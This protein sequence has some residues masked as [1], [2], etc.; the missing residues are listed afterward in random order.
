MTTARAPHGSVVHEFE[1]RVSCQASECARW[2]LSCRM[3]SQS[4]AGAT[5]RQPALSEVEGSCPPSPRLCRPG[6]GR[7]TKRVP[8]GSRSSRA[9]A[10]GSVRCPQRV[11]SVRCPQRIRPLGTADT[12]TRCLA[13][14]RLTTQNRSRPRTN[15]VADLH[16]AR[17]RPRNAPGR[18]VNGTLRFSGGAGRFG[19]GLVPPTRDPGRRRD[20][21]GISKNDAGILKND[22][23]I[24]TKYPG[25]LQNDL[26]FRPVVC[27]ISAQNSCRM[28]N[29]C[30]SRCFVL[31]PKSRASKRAFPSLVPPSFS[32]SCPPSFQSFSFG[33]HLSSK[34][35]F[36][37]VR[38]AMCIRHQEAGASRTC[39]LPSWSLGARTDR[40]RM[41]DSCRSPLGVVVC[42]RA[43]VALGRTLVFEA[44]LRRATHLGSRWMKLSFAGKCVPKCNLGTR[45]SRANSVL[46]PR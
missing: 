20:D 31:A 21:A 43:Q 27:P 24:W 22:R 14:K 16:D 40:G 33:T 17:G 46:P 1:R 3:N 2:D 10:P 8:H 39:A 7:A 12:A 34:L 30:R 4:R 6:G 23:S 44:V 35:C 15:A 26:D 28:T 9:S 45:A 29:S 37:H 18:R 11:C 41:T 36:A 5:A 38:P 13:S 42:P 19:G 32:P 25:R